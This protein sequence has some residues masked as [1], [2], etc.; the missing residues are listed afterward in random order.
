MTRRA[1][2]ARL[3]KRIGLTLAAVFLAWVGLVVIRG[4]VDFAMQPHPLSDLMGFAIFV[5][6]AI[7]G[8]IVSVGLPIAAGII[9]AAICARRP[10]VAGAIAGVVA[11]GVVCAL[12]VSLMPVLRATGIVH[13]KPFT[14]VGLFAPIAWWGFWGNVGGACMAGWREGRRMRDVPAR[15]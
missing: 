11:M 14:W 5:L 8:L 1:F 6:V 10:R 13:I 15:S 4:I 3:A 2:L 12:I 9:G 7:A